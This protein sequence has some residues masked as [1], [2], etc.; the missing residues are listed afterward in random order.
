MIIK[1]RHLEHQDE[2]QH[3][4]WLFQSDFNIIKPLWAVLE[5]KSEKQ[6]PSSNISEATGRVFFL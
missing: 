6:I 2:I 3:L 1:P 4:P 5:D